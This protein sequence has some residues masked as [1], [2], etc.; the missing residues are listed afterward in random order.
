ML[1][2]SHDHHFVAELATR[3]IELHDRP[4]GDAGEGAKV[5]EFQG[6]YEDFLQRMR[7][8]ASA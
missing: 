4:A 6:S 5:V 2:V 1:F 7:E 3:I 8:R